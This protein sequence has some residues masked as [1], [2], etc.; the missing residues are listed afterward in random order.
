MSPRVSYRQVVEL[1]GEELGLG[2]GARLVGWGGSGPDTEG[3]ASGG[4]QQVAAVSAGGAIIDMTFDP[5]EPF[6]VRM[7]TTHLV[8]TASGSGCC[9][10]WWFWRICSWRKTCCCCFRALEEAGSGYRLALGLF[11]LAPPPADKALLAIALGSPGGGI[12]SKAAPAAP[13]L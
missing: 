6:T 4:L 10:C 8:A 1:C 11:C 9:D 12:R 5:P 3:P 13:P 2:R 7:R